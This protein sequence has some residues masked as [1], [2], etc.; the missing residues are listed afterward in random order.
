[1]SRTLDL[2]RRQAWARRAE[3][4]RDAGPARDRWCV[5]RLLE[6]GDL[7]PAQHSAAVRFARLTE[8]GQGQTSGARSEAIDGGGCDPHARLWDAALC[9]REAECARMSV[10]TNLP[11]D[12]DR[13]TRVAVFEAALSFPHRSVRDAMADAGLAHGGRTRD[14]FIAHLVAALDLLVIYFDAVDAAAARDFAR[15]A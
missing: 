5:H 9:A 6:C 14:V 3:Y 11:D 10:L 7:A 2:A 8:R 4:G 1:M 13:R 12:G 15:S